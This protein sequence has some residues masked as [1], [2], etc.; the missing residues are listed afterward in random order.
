M[1]I[2]VNWLKD[3]VK[4]SDPQKTGDDLTMSIAE[5]EEIEDLSQKFYGIIIG[6][7]IEKKKHPNADRL[8]LAKVN[9]GKE[10]LDIVCGA[11]NLEE[12]QKVPVAVI[13]T[14]LQNGMV[15]K[16]VAI[17]GQKSFGMIC[18][19]EELGLAKKSEG[20]LALDKGAKVGEEFSKYQNLDDIIFNIDNKSLT[21]RSDLFCHIGIAREI[22]AAESKKLSLPKLPKIK[23]VNKKIA[24]EIKDKNLCFRY[25]AIKLDDIKIGESPLWMQSR[26]T[27]AGMRPINNIVDITNYVMLEFGQPLHAF[28]ADKIGDKIVVRKAKKG[29]SLKTI[30]AKV[31][32]LD[33]EMLI[34]ADSKKPIAVAGVMGGFDSEVSKN[35]KSIILESANFYAYSI[36]QTARKLGLH[37]EAAT[38][39]EKNIAPEL[40]S[41]AMLRAVQLFQEICKAKIASSVSDVYSSKHKAIKIKLDPEKADEF[42]GEKIPLSKI[43]SILKSLEFK[44]TGTKNL[45]VEVPYFRMDIHN[46][47]DLFEEIA[48]IYGYDNIKPQ[49]L[50]QIL[51]PVANLADLKLGNNARD[52]LAGFGFSETYNYSF[53]SQNL[54][55]KSGFNFTQNIKV[56][57]PQSKDLQ[58]LRTSLLPGLLENV[59]LNSKRFESIKIFEIGHVYQDIEKKYLSGIISGKKEKIFYN[60]KGVLEGLL[61][62]LNITC[63]F[64]QLEE[65]PK[66]LING[67]SIEIK[68]GQ[69]IIGK[70][71]LINQNNLDQM[72]IKKI[73]VAFFELDI[74]ELVD[75]SKKDKK[76]QAIPKFPE[77][78]LDLAFILDKTIPAATIEREILKAGHPLLI[79]AKLFDVY[80]GKP[81]QSNERNLAYHLIYQDPNKTLQDQEVKIIQQKIINQLSQKFQAK[82]RK[83]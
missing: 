37:S 54:L 69:K 15:I 41:Y 2:S 27:S 11:P 68:Q 83:Q 31:R 53:V 28:D 82:V 64:A 17:R 13:G 16:P 23:K 56:L 63:Q 75:A 62:K 25:M 7:V 20:I 22:A 19:E 42:L 46:Q 79:K 3:Y 67:K 10:I 58:Y 66:Y 14:K 35:T 70:M 80:T 51:E 48:R 77:V 39:F 12:G 18:S 49:A 32:Q 59:R 50:I 60:L 24:V 81:L 43:K 9:I 55:Q 30:D 6:E 74:N 34:I 26:L 73:K 21:H 71:G 65:T 57:N 52:I 8:N 29:E 5:V 61:I 38:R 1:K 47:E 36:R 40:A 72:G 4:I 76:F 45:I 44:I 78:T 33:S